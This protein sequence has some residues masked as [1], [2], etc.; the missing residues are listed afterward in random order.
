[1]GTGE[2]NGKIIGALGEK[3]QEL[4]EKGKEN[5]AWQNRLASYHDGTIVGQEFWGKGSRSR[6]T[7]KVKAWGKGEEDGNLME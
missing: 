3:E 5:G 1:M 4:W 7:G 6:R 2:G